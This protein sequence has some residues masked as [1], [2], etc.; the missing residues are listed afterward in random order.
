MIKTKN[1]SLQTKNY[2]GSALLYIML[3][4][5]TVGT[6]ALGAARFMVIET[7]MSTQMTDAIIASWL[8][9]ASIEERLWD[10]FKSPPPPPPPKIGLVIPTSGATSSSVAFAYKDFD[11]GQGNGTSDIT[12]EGNRDLPQDRQYLNKVWG[13]FVG[14]TD[15]LYENYL[16]RSISPETELRFF[17]SVNSSLTWAIGDWGKNLDQS[18]WA[19]I[20]L[21]RNNQLLGYC[22]TTGLQNL[23]INNIPWSS[24][25]S[26]GTITE[27]NPGSPA[28]Y[29]IRIADTYSNQLYSIV[30]RVRPSAGSNLDIDSGF[31][32]FDSY[33]IFG[34]AKEKIRVKINKSTPTILFSRTEI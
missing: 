30:F 28:R 15:E 24:W 12:T 34:S 29:T 26:C 22:T 1:L 18:Y 21:L 13:R 25:G 33:G 9:N 7:K 4:I 19:K 2:K 11:S 10:Y 14:R 31:K 6:I 3:L 16:I 8:A 17:N 32:F 23:P 5:A 27:T 20:A